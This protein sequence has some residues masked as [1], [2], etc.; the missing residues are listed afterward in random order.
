MNNKIMRF[1][2]V[3]SLLF[4]FSMLIS[5]GYSYYKQSRHTIPLF[6]SQ[7]S[8]SG[9][10]IE[11]ISLKPEQQ[12]AIKAKAHAFHSSIEAARERTVSKHIELL[13]LLRSDSPDPETINRKIAEIGSLQGNI[14]KIAAAHMLEVK[15][16]LDHEQQDKFFDLMQEAMKAKEQAKGIW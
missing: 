1:A 7:A 9:H 8:K 14:Q 15:V 4:N 12:E 11:S 10:L 13:S 2:L 5:A 6:C 3:I 16:L